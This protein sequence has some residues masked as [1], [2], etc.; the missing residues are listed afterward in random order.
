MSPAPPSSPQFGGDGASS[1]ASRNVKRVFLRLETVSL[2]APDNGTALAALVLIYLFLTFLGSFRLLWHDELYTL[3]IAS[4]PSWPRL[5]EEIRLDLNPP[6]EYIAVRIS[7][8]LFGQ[9]GYAVRLPS[10]L[11]FLGGS[12]CFYRFV[13]KRLDNAYA[14]LAVLVI[15]ASPFFYYATEARPYALAIGFMGFALLAWQKATEPGRTAFS[16]G[17]F[18][19]ALVGLM[20]SHLMAPLYVL[21]FC[22]AEVLRS[23]R[24]K[25]VDAGLWIALLAPCAIPFLYVR[26]MSRFESS[27]FPAAFQASR[28]ISVRP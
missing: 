8:E 10:I 4:A 14:L 25:R 21:P 3:Y 27:V 2:S 17:L 5:W 9:S 26:L 1:P 16:L 20:L 15:W 23:R 28:S 6:L 22:L 13:A 24:L 12:L 7:T 11:A 18:V 19:V